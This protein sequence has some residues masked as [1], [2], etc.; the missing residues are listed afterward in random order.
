ME[1]IRCSMGVDKRGQEMTLKDMQRMIDF[2]SVAYD[3]K[4]TWFLYCHKGRYFALDYKDEEQL[5]FYS[6]EEAHDYIEKNE[7]NNREVRN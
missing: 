4:D 6:L 7:Q 5:H 3:E 1:I 2:E